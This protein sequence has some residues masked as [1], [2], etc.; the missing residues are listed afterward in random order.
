M[1]TIT[2]NSRQTTTMSATTALNGFCCGNSYPQIGQCAEL[3]GTVTAQ[4]GHSRSFI[5][6]FTFNFQN[7][8]SKI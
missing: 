4:D 1:K 6:C 8:N 3:L 7:H 2:G 5:F